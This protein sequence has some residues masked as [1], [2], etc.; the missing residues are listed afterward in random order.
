V[1]TPKDL[2]QQ[3]EEGL[4]CCSS[5]A[6]CQP[7]GVWE[8]DGNDDGLPGPDLAETLD[9]CVKGL[10]KRVLFPEDCDCGAGG[11]ECPSGADACAEYVCL[12]DCLCLAVSPLFSSFECCASDLDCIDLNDYT[13]DK[14]VDFTC[15]YKNAWYDC[16]AYG[17][18]SL[19]CGGF[20]YCMDLL[21]AGGNYCYEVLIVHPDCFG[22]YLRCLDDADCGDCDDATV[23][24]C[25]DNYCHYN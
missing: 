18:D 22:P 4:E 3:A 10:C 8:E 1:G 9:L 16:G 20:D 14:C 11:G 5:D 23:D 21:C 19:V 25:I 17:E 2:V 15:T 6:D 12:A 7:G 24:V 13:V